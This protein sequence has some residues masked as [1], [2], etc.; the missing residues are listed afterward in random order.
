MPVVGEILEDVYASLAMGSRGFTWAPLAAELLASA[1]AGAASPVE[2]T[3][4]N[5]MLPRRFL[6]GNKH[7]K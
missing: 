3:V 1:I 4:V 2:R 6:A 5:G 7:D